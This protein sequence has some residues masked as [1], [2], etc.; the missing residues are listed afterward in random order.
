MDQEGDGVLL[1]E[2]F[3]SS[4]L[5]ERTARL[6]SLSHLQL[7]AATLKAMPVVLI[8]QDDQLD[9]PEDGL[10]PTHLF[11]S[12]FFQMK[13]RYVV[14]NAKTGKG[15]LRPATKPRSGAK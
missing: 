8:P 10:L 5:K 9:R 4:N 7:G 11:Q 3:S 2:F 14:L 13:D 15:A 12:V 1:L 6:G